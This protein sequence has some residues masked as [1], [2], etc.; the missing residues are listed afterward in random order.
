MEP[1]RSA[2]QKL[3][4]AIPASA[5]G[6]N[7]RNRCDRRGLSMEKGPTPRV[8]PDARDKRRR[9]MRLRCSAERFELNG[10]WGA[11]SGAQLERV[12]GACTARNARSTRQNAWRVQK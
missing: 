7:C 3:V 12:K 10:S 2:L 5:R 8:A 11:S 1:R 6:E 9:R 4:M